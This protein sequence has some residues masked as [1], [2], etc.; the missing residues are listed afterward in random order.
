MNTLYDNPNTQAMMREGCG[1]E[2][3]G[4][5]YP[6]VKQIAFNRIRRETIFAQLVDSIKP[7]EKA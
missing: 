1:T 2:Y 6:I 4:P 5:G 7:E 3:F